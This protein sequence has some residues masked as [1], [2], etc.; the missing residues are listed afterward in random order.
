MKDCYKCKTSKPVSEFHKNKNKKDGLQNYCKACAKVRN[1]E[2]YIST[3]ERNPQRR[4]SSRKMIEASREHVWE[5]LLS[6]PCVDCFESDP[7]VLEFDHVRGVKR[8]AI[9]EMIKRYMSIKTIDLEIAKCEV[10]CANCHR[11]VTAK[12]GGWYA[13]P[14]DIPL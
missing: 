13:G 9:S 11:R 5:Y 2:Y 1:R 6:H 8:L 7:A 3:P 4:A 12:R 10:R 14:T